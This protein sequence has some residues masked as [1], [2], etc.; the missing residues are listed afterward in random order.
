[1]TIEAYTDYLYLRCGSGDGSVIEVNANAYGADATIT[2]YGDDAPEGMPTPALT[3]NAAE[4]VMFGD[5]LMRLGE[6]LTQ[7]EASAS[8]PEDVGL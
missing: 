4:L 5:W 8:R 2:F 7:A 6:R 3:V 1:M